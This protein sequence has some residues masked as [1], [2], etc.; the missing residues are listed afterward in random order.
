MKKE[1]RKKKERQVFTKKENWL[2]FIKFGFF[3]IS[4]GGIQALSFTIIYEITDE[5]SWWGAYLPALVLSVIWNFTLNRKF[6]F[7]SA[8][9]IS[10][11]MMKVFYYYLVFTPISV[12]GGQYLEFT[13]GWNGYIVTGMMMIL[14]FVTEFLFTKYVVYK[15]QINTAVRVKKNGTLEKGLE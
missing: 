14:N 8:A 7:Q 6:T 5:V 13:R 3:S 4:A 15:N 9:N 12:F 2:H 11:A 10:K 1:E